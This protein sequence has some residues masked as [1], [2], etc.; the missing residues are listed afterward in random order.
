M[1]QVG[2][3]HSVGVIGNRKVKGNQ[4]NIVNALG[5]HLKFFI[6]T[7][8][9]TSIIDLVKHWENMGILFI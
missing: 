3:Q 7:F 6:V 8:S 2:T 4:F 9:R 5:H 1:T